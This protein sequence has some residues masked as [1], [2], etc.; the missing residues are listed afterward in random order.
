MLNEKAN[1][2]QCPTTTVAYNVT[3]F[4]PVEIR[5]VLN[6]KE[7]KDGTGNIIL[8]EGRR[9]YWG[10]LHKFDETKAGIWIFDNGI[11]LVGENAKNLDVEREIKVLFNQARANETEMRVIKTF[12]MHE[13]PIELFQPT[14]KCG[15]VRYYGG[16]E[17]FIFEAG[18]PLDGY[19][20]AIA[21]LNNGFSHQGDGSVEC[22][23]QM[24]EGKLQCQLM[25]IFGLASTLLNILDLKV[26]IYFIGQENK[27]EQIIQLINGLFANPNE[28]KNLTYAISHITTC[29]NL[30]TRILGGLPHFHLIKTA[31]SQL[32]KGV[33][34][35]LINLI[36]ENNETLAG[37][38]YF[39]NGSCNI[40]YRPAFQYS[41]GNFVTLN[42]L[43]CEIDSLMNKQLL[44]YNK[45]NYGYLGSCF[46]SI[47]LK[48]KDKIIEDH[49]NLSM[50]MMEQN[51]SKIE[52][53]LINIRAV[54]SIA[55]KVMQCMG[56]ELNEDELL[57]EL[58]KNNSSMVASLRRKS[59]VE[60]AQEIVQNI[61]DIDLRTVK[62]KAVLHSHEIE[63]V[64]DKVEKE[65]GGAI[66]GKEI[67]NIL[68]DLSI[69]D[70]GSTNYTRKKYSS[71]QI[72][73]Y[74]FNINVGM[75][76]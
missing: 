24:F 52:E 43:V 75:E 72:T 16:K 30:K 37:G 44:N 26:G 48:N 47:V 42:N 22:L 36:K 74:L 39:I 9:V 62:N 71:N 10:C 45:I 54:C 11:K 40:S 12:S 49:N 33:I 66:R 63:D 35:Y 23:N 25:L 68:I 56:F 21:I 17:I 18:I 19:G 73:G 70:G 34:D 57:K 3:T 61:P 29:S 41:V 46:T 1:L 55:I 2:T 20:N 60:K 28:I 14:K 67:R 15:L 4:R 38:T 53:N 76:G 65:L 58:D 31:F 59:I 5:E 32:K 69:L 6:G 50:E 7:M 8:L 51:E 13:E 27:L 64:I